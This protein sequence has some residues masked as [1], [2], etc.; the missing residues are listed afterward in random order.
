MIS[1]T[2][3]RCAFLHK[4]TIPQGFRPFVRNS[5]TRLLLVLLCFSCALAQIEPT[6]RNP[7][8]RGISSG[9]SSHSLSNRSS[10]TKDGITWTFS[11]SVPVGQFVNGDYYVVGSVTITS[12]A[13]PP[14]T[15]KPY[16][17]GSV[18]NLPSSNGK[19]GFDS[20]VGSYWFD[21]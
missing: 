10:I 5:S 2:Y 11:R 9:T 15:S 3:R 7:A 19:S 14:T 4:V 6:H 1:S 13:P 21:A 20:R 18:V 12:I 17:N 16:K 8:S